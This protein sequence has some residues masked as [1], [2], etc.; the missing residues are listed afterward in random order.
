MIE[1]Y[2]YLNRH[3][4][5]ITNGIFKV[6]KNKFNVRNYHVFQRK[7]P[8]WLKYGLGA[9]PY[10]ASQLWQQVPVDIREAASLSL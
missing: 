4:P 6:R 5:G 3:S 1:V 10:H 8:R 9:I 7:T 2:K